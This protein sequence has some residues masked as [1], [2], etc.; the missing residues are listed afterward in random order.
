[1]SGLA[2]VP[3]ARGGGLFLFALL[4]S[5]VFG[6]GLAASLDVAITVAAVVG[7]VVAVFKRG[8]GQDLDEDEW[9]EPP[10][11]AGG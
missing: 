1:M 9:Q 11:P 8:R 7:A 6:P 2:E 10:P 4:L 3:I 5:V